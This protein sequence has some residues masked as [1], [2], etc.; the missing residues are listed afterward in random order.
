M[1][2]RRPRKAVV[3]LA[4]EAPGSDRPVAALVE[5]L[6]SLGIETTWLGNEYSPERIAAEV[7]AVGADAV[8]LC[9][10]KGAAGVLML[11]ALLR[12][13]VQIDRRDVSIVVHRLAR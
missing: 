5:S 7:A 12:E 13:L 4:G 2:T 8:E 3:V 6:H 10:G 11:R 9:L 1:A